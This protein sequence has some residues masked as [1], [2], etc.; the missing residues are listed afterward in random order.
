MSSSD[1][2]ET[3]MVE[4]IYDE[5]SDT[6]HKWNNRV[7]KSIREDNLDTFWNS[8]MYDKVYYMLLICLI[9]YIFYIFMEFLSMH[10]IF[11]VFLSILYNVYR[12][13]NN[14]EM[15]W[16]GKSKF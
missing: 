3:D 11:F 15:L 14:M 7:L 9:C 1:N 10:S 2:Q 12:M 8:T 4:R 13:D 5:V 6:I 16:F